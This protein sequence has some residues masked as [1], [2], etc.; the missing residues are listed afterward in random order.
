MTTNNE[1]LKAQ[2]VS[3]ASVLFASPAFATQAN[4][5]NIIGLADLFYNYITGT[6]K[7]TAEN[8]QGEGEPAV[9]NP[10]TYS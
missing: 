8:K 2:C 3:A 6:V 5:Q 10:Q 4:P 7:V 9:A 1:I